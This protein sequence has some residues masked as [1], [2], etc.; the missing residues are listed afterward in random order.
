MFKT[1][2]KNKATEVTNESNENEAQEERFGSLIDLSR[3][4]NVGNRPIIE[5]HDLSGPSR[6][7]EAL[8][9]QL[10]ENA[11]AYEIGLF[12]M[13]VCHRLTCQFSK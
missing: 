13:Q 8:N 10:D 4:I 3:T 12:L 2:P 7:I 5:R 9:T 6:S 1:P 11:V